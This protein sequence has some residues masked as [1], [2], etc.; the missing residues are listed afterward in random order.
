MPSET[1]E[2]SA[3]VEPMGATAHFQPGLRPC[4]FCQDVSEPGSDLCAR[5]E[6]DERLAKEWQQ[7]A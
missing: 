4:R 2:Q 1:P 3:T 5:C 7:S 6:D